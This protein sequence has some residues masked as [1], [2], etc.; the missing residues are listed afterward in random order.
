MKIEEV[1]TGKSDQ[2]LVDMEEL[3]N[4]MACLNEKQFQE[5]AVLK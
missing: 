4:C 3:K 2:G 5:R 1:I